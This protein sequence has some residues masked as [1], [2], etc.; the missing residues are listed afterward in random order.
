MSSDL[1][2]ITSYQRLRQNQTPSIFPVIFYVKV[3]Y[4]KLEV[5][6]KRK[7]KIRKEGRKEEKEEKERVKIKFPI[8]ESAHEKF[9]HSLILL[10]YLH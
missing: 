6:C 8:I 5:T 7:I 3:K 4:R 10:Y 2:R 9:N 1:E